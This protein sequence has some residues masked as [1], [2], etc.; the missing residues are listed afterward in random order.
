VKFAKGSSQDLHIDEPYAAQK[1]PQGSEAS[2][3]SGARNHGEPMRC[4]EAL[5]LWEEAMAGQ[6]VDPA[7]LEEVLR[8]MGQ[9]QERCPEVLAASKIDTIEQM[10]RISGR[11]D[12]YEALG[13]SYEEE[14]D[15]HHR[16]Y[17]RL[18]KSS[19]ASAEE[20]ER[21]RV[22]ALENWERAIKNYEAGTRFFQSIFLVDAL[23][24]M[25][26]KPK[27]SAPTAR[28]A[29]SPALEELLYLKQMAHFTPRPGENYH[30]GRLTAVLPSAVQG[31]PRMG[32][33]SAGWT[34]LAPGALPSFFR[35]A[36]PEDDP[37]EQLG[38]WREAGQDLLR[39]EGKVGPFALALAAALDEEDRW[40]L[41]VL[42]QPRL[43]D[44]QELLVLLN[45]HKVG[46]Q[47]RSYLV[48]AHPFFRH[49][50]WSAP[51]RGI[52]G[53][54]YYLAVTARQKSGEWVA[55]DLELALVRDAQEEHP[56]R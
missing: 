31:K 7:R 8:H 54:S 4:E 27:L 18:S 30:K 10:A 17:K 33:A 42:V 6:K 56:A 50:V 20:L 28:P 39:V 19:R 35:A 45:L 36:E 26:R 14:G 13:L 51:F 2:P 29:A 25:K 55:A 44:E 38:A 49:G 5:R 46:P 1:T 43:P 16:R 23:K 48:T 37:Q 34:L 11:G 22:L 9:C 24:R 21:E 41:R 53:G 15:A 47:A 12:V 52:V 32:R 40:N 3:V